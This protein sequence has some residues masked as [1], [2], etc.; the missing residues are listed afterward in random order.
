MSIAFA[1]AM[2]FPPLAAVLI[3]MAVVGWGYRECFSV[4]TTRVTSSPGS[5]SRCLSA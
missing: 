5:C 2:V 4:F 1:Y 3:P